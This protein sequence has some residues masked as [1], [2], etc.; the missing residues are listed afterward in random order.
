[1]AFQVWVM[2]MTIIALLNESIPHLIAAFLTHIL[3]TTW[4]GF[5]I[6]STYQFR[7]EFQQATSKAESCDTNVLPDYWSQ[8]NAAEV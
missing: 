1:M 5:Q 3:A 4:S 7:K 6:Y 8:R 2:G